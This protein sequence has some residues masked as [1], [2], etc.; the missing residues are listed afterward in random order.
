MVV[1]N[2]RR[3]DPWPSRLTRVSA[4]DD[5]FAAVQARAGGTPYVVEPTPAGFDVRPATD[6][7]QWFG[8]LREGHLTETAIHHV[9]V[10]GAAR[11]VRIADELRT[12]TW[13]AGTDGRERPQLGASVGVSSGRST[14][15]RV[16]RTYS[17]SRNGFTQESETTFDSAAGRDLVEATATDLGWKLERGLNE[18]I[19]LYV[20][21]TTIVLLVLAG[22]GVGIAA[23][24]GAFS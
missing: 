6:D 22:I 9:T 1:L 15:R 7:P 17:L 20:G 18:R 24:A 3:S 5:L 12:L 14:S 16:Q 10:D 23:L 19:G 11:T 4:T 2:G 8:R 21:V 13:R